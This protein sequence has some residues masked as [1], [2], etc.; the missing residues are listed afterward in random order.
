VINDDD[1]MSLSCCLIK[2]G[3]TRQFTFYDLQNFVFVSFKTSLS[4]YLTHPLEN[5]KETSNNHEGVVGS[6][7]LVNFL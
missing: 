3:G 5:I 4:C 1:S 6:E 7:K 2:K